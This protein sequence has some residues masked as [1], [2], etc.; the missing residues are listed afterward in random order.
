MKIDLKLTNKNL[1]P[2]GAFTI[3]GTKDYVYMHKILHPYDF[4]K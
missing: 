3:K 2:K 4:E 1:N